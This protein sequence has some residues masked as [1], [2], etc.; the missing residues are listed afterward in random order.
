[1]GVDEGEDVVPGIG[2]KP[3]D[4][5]V[6]PEPCHLLAGVDAGV[7]L[8]FLYGKVEAALVAEAGKE[9][10][11][12]DGVEG[13]GDGALVGGEAP[14]EPPCL[15]Q[16]AVRHHL[17]H[18]HIDALVELFARAGEANL[19][20]A[21]G[22]GTAAACSE[23]GVGAARHVADFQGVEDALGVLGV[24]DCIVVGVEQAQFLHQRFEALALI[25]FEQRGAGVGIDGGNVVDAVAHGVDIHHAAACEQQR[26]MGGEESGRE[27]EDVGFVHRCAVVVVDAQRADEVVLAATELLVRRSGC[28]DAHV[29]VELSA[30]G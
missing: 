4:G 24:N 13:V 26:R 2:V 30:I 14:V 25:A 12:A 5:R 28:A 23:R 15:V 11:V 21:E 29:A 9:L 20:Y 10:L 3:V 22:A 16:Q 8:D 27:A 7:L 6:A 1:M 19:Q 17:V 18:A